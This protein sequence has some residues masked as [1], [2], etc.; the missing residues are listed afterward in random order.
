MGRGSSYVFRCHV[1]D[2]TD[3]VQTQKACGEQ[4]DWVITSMQFYSE[5]H[6]WEGRFYHL[7][8]LSPGQDKWMVIIVEVN[9][10]ERGPAP[11]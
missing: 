10:P 8:L 6:R 4:G 2:A 1:A 3:H 9:G 11:L 5:Y 7:P